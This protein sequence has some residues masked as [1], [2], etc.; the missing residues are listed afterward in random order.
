MEPWLEVVKHENL[1][2]GGEHLEG[3]RGGEAWAPPACRPPG[4]EIAGREPEQGPG[5]LT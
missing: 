3:L 4:P 1:S 5:R 2:R